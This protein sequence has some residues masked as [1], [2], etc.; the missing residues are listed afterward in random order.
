M[1][2][3]R[4]VYLSAQIAVFFATLTFSAV[5]ALGALEYFDGLAM[6]A[7]VCFLQVFLMY[8]ITQVWLSRRL[9]VIETWID[10][11]MGNS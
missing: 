9:P 4:I 11:K 5:F 8:G 7:A 6:I 3:G 1:T 10:D 2:I